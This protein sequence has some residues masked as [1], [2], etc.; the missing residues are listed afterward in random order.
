MALRFLPPIRHD[1]R[2]PS[3]GHIP[4]PDR[5]ILR[6]RGDPLPVRAERG[7]VDGSLVAAQDKV[8]LLKAKF[9]V[10]RAELDVQKNEL[11][12]TIDARMR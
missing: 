4:D 5:R 1:E 9:E 2:R 11:V 7:T 10:R 12:S 6:D 3:P 8:A